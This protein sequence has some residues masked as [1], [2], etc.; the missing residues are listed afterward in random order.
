MF[1]E[2]EHK[3]LVS[4]HSFSSADRDFALIEKKEKHSKME[5]MDDLKN[6]IQGAR[7]AKPFKV[8][9]MSNKFLDFHKA[10]LAY[11]DTKKLGISKATWLKVS[12]S[13]PGYVQHKENLSELGAFQKTYIFKKNVTNQKIIDLELN[14]LPLEVPLSENKKKD[15]SAML[16]YISQP[17]RGFY[18]ELCA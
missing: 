4:G 1:T 3:F 13:Y 16:E 14:S 15:I 12:D 5:S 10:S 17:N 6:I 8:L 11:I 9:D 2:I 7:P 18:E